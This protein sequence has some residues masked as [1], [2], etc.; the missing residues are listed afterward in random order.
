MNGSGRTILTTPRDGPGDRSPPCP[1]GLSI[2][3]GVSEAPDPARSPFDAARH[4]S[5][6]CLTLFVA[7]HETL[8]TA[9][10]HS[11]KIMSSSGADGLPRPEGS[12]STIGRDRDTP[13]G[14][15]TG[16]AGVSRTV[17]EPSRDATWSRPTSRQAYDLKVTASN[18]ATAIIENAA[19]L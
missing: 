19:K 9:G 5:L 12:L 10:R 8:A 18:P 7:P 13:R 16:P 17:P 15:R 3:R 2:G 1:V 14:G 4:P 11:E 6:C